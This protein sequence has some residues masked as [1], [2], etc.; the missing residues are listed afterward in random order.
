MAAVWDWILCKNTIRNHNGGRHSCEK[1]RSTRE[2]HFMLNFHTLINITQFPGKKPALFEGR[3]MKFIFMTEKN[4]RNFFAI[5][6]IC[7][8]IA[9]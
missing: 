4:R 6:L 2:L 1:Q 5:L 9:S 7:I 8:L 3:R